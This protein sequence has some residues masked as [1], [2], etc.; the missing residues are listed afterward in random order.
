MLP[1]MASD[2]GHFVNYFWDD[3]PNYILPIWVLL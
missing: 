3:T 1:A 2:S